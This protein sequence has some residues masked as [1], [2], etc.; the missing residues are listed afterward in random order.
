M[1]SLLLAVPQPYVPLQAQQRTALYQPTLLLLI[2]RNT[3]RHITPSPIE[4]RCRARHSHQ[5][6]QGDIYHPP[7]AHTPPEEGVELGANL[8]P[9]IYPPLSRPRQPPP[10][11]PMLLLGHDRHR[12]DQPHQLRSRLD[13]STHLQARLLAMAGDHARPSLRVCSLR[14]PRLFLVG[15]WTLP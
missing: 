7:E 6:G 3:P 1:S 2:P 15:N 13:R 5:L 12:M 4:R 8:Q 9:G 11:L 10:D 14:C